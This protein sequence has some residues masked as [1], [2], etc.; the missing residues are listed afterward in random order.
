MSVIKWIEDNFDLVKLDSTTEFIY[1]LMDSQSEKS[2]PIIYQPF[3]LHDKS[4]FIDRGQILDFV[5]STRSEENPGKEKILDLGPGDGWP[6]LLISPFVSEIWGIDASKRRIMECQ[7]NA[8]RLNFSNAIYKLNPANE[9]LPIPNYYFDGVV[10]ASSIEQTPDPKETLVELFHSLRPGGKLRL[11]YEALGK[12][13]NGREKEIG[14]TGSGRTTYLLIF[15]RDTRNGWVTQYRINIQLSKEQ[16]IDIFE[17]FNQ[18]VSYSGLSLT[19]LENLKK[20]TFG[21]FYCKTYHPDCETYIKWLKEIGFS[22]V[23]PTHNGGEFCRRYY[24]LIPRSQRPPNFSSVDVMLMP[25]IEAITKMEAP[26][27]TDPWITAVK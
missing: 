11:S 20:H 23:L 7:N 25:I 4:H 12:Y 22:Q 26:L 5:V 17:K 1:D 27:H 9:P 21:A 16:T 19:V 24:N 2:L 3:N 10:A 13:K 14:M 6:S 15:D 18:E 8:E